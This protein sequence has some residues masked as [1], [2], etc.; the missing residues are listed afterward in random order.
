MLS[1]DF[2]ITL[3]R[4]LQL[5][6]EVA[7]VFFAPWPVKLHVDGWCTMIERPGLLHG[8]IVIELEFVEL[9]PITGQVDVSLA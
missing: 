9:Y 5:Y 4:Q 3:T 2:K 7:G 8:L 6:L 1:S